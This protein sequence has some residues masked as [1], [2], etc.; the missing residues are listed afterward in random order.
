MNVILP[1]I[2]ATRDP[3]A[4]LVIGQHCKWCPNK[5]NCPALKGETFEFPMGIES[6]HL[7]NEE[8][9]EA[10]EKLEAI[11]VLQQVLEAEALRRARSGDKIPGRK[12][13]RKKANRKFKESMALPDP[14]DPDNTVEVKLED[15][16]EERFGLDAYGE[17]KLR[18]PNQ[19]EALEGG[20]EFTAK[21]AYTP[22]MGLT[23]AKISDKRMEVSTNIERM[24]GTEV[25]G[26]L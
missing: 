14:N 10:L 8:L 19:L 3:S 23:L 2:E 22:D 7:T 17:P 13:V 20:S 6:T 11:L 18:S 24:R 15:A 4:P 26:V 16:I 25:T 21:W 9:G 5:G 1:G 12:L